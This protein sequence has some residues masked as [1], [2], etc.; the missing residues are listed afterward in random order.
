MLRL[1]I[2]VFGPFCDVIFCF[3]FGSCLGI[4]NRCG[5]F[6]YVLSNVMLCVIFRLSSIYGAL[7]RILS[8]FGNVMVCVVLFLPLFWNVYVV[9][10]S[11]DVI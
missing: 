1:N 11:Y 5:V 2:A 6:W 10:G 7:Y 9:F 8:L 3:V 4:L